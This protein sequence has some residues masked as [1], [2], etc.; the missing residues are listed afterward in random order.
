VFLA[1]GLVH[2]FQRVVLSLVLNR[3]AFEGLLAL[4][5]AQLKGS[6]TGVDLVPNARRRDLRFVLSNLLDFPLGHG[7]LPP[8]KHVMSRHELQPPAECSRLAGWLS[9]LRSIRSVISLGTV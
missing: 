6:R 4:V 9:R 1:A 2:S 8:A 7:V 3:N 5:R